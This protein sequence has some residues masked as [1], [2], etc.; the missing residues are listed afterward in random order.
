MVSHSA[1]NNRSDPLQP[2]LL[3]INPYC[4]I[5]HP[6]KCISI[7]SSTTHSPVI[8]CIEHHSGMSS[9]EHL[10]VFFTSASTLLMKLHTVSNKQRIRSSRPIQ[11][12]VPRNRRDWVNS[13]GTA[14]YARLDATNTN[15]CHGP[16]QAPRL[17]DL[18]SLNMFQAQLES[19][20]L[21]S[22]SLFTPMTQSVRIYG[23]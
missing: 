17:F 11:S 1:H 20:Q 21:I 16:M 7:T 14:A 19:S 23:C 13:A 3:A 9:R 6:G 15:G 8:Q 5:K 18:L 4:I 2:L 12:F 10:C 22:I